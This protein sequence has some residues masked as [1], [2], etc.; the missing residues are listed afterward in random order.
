MTGACHTACSQSCGC[1]PAHTNH[2]YLALL[3]PH[4]VYL[5]RHVKYN[6]TLR[7]MT[8]LPFIPNKSPECL[9]RKKK[10]IGPP[11]VWM[12]PGPK[13][14]KNQKIRLMPVPPNIRTLHNLMKKYCVTAQKVRHSSTEEGANG[15]RTIKSRRMMLVCGC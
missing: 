11:S 4:P 13:K 1:S 14:T 8:N 15:E 7:F 10:K 3:E 9:A 2:F 5:E 12:Q 6:M